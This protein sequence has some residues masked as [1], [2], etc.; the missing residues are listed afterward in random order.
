MTSD[1]NVHELTVAVVPDDTHLAVV[2]WVV[3]VSVLVLLAASTVSAIID[4][5][6]GRPRRAVVFGAATVILSFV[7]VGGMDMMER[8][9]PRGLI[10]C[11]E[12]WCVTTPQVT[13][14]VD[15]QAPFK[16]FEYTFESDR[17]V[18]ATGL[19]V[20]PN[21]WGVP[22]NEVVEVRLVR[23]TRF[24]SEGVVYRVEL[25]EVLT[26][27]KRTVVRPESDR[28]AHPN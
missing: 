28:L 18:R 11:G 24:R 8:S 6:T 9:H 23:V 21:R 7:L 27:P 19:I 22:V 13:K 2:A 14:A 15:M 3:V 4:G 1:E 17:S 10:G 12:R 16:L 25:I 26:G 5:S 20:A